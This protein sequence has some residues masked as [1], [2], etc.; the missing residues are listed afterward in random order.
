MAL[1]CMTHK[2]CTADDILIDKSLDHVQAT[3]IIIFP[4]KNVTGSE[5]KKHKI[6]KILYKE[7]KQPHIS[8]AFVH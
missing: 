7:N 8:I 1:Y 5:K 4:Y 6:A 3:E 2:L